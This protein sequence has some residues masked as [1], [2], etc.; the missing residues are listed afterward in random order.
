MKIKNCL[1]SLSFLAFA[2]FL[3]SNIV[4]YANG[5]SVYNQIINSSQNEIA[6]SVYI[7][8]R[9]LYVINI[10]FEAIALASLIFVI[11][12]FF[13]SLLR[14]KPTRNFYFISCAFV[15]VSLYLLK[16]FITQIYCFLNDYASGSLFT[17]L[18][19]VITLTAITALFAFY[20]VIEIRAVRSTTT[21]Q[22]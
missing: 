9:N 20:T 15:L 5:I 17:C 1:I 4:A 3:V 6:D 10:I 16:T 13:S 8:S 18:S 11:G 21:P 22:N 19:S 12:Y 2:L 14:R 7:F